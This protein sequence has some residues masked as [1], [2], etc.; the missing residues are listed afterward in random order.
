MNLQT[1]YKP[2]PVRLAQFLLFLNITVG[3][4][5]GSSLVTNHPQIAAYLALGAGILNTAVQVFVGQNSI[6]P[7]EEN[8]LD[9]TLSDRRD[10]VQKERK[11]RPAK[12][13]RAEG[14]AA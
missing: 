1:Y 14:G 9:S 5:A 7:H 12:S 3:L 6:Q 11:A 10:R 8:S 13:R 2:I 4:I